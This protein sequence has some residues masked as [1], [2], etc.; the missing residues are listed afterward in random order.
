MR[1]FLRSLSTPTASLYL[2]IIITQV[3]A[4]VYLARG[5]EPPPAFSFLYPLGLLWAGGWWLRDDSR[6]RGVGWPFD[7]G[8]FLYIA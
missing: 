8:L 2:F 4:G 5:A 1:D 6:K 3:A 7:M